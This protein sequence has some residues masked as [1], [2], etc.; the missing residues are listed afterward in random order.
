MEENNLNP[1]EPSRPSGQKATYPILQRNHLYCRTSFTERIADWFDHETKRRAAAAKAESCRTKSP[2]TPG[3]PTRIQPSRTAKRKAID[4]A[5]AAAAPKKRDKLEPGDYVLPAHVGDDDFDQ[6]Q[7]QVL[8]VLD[9]KIAEM[10]DDPAGCPQEAPR[11]AAADMPLGCADMAYC[12]HGLGM[13]SKSLR[14]GARG[15]GAGAKG[16]APEAKMLL[17]PTLGRWSVMPVEKE[18]FNSQVVDVAGLSFAVDV[19]SGSVRVVML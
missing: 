9:E 6:F 4:E 16:T 1:I 18:V 11:C 8:F 12:L 19:C 3:P 7:Q 10:T 15:R 5:A 17:S 13:K 14:A 2:S